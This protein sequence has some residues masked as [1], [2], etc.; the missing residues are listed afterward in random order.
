MIISY[1]ELMPVTNRI[2][3]EIGWN[4][5]Q[6]HLPP[7]VANKIQ[8]GATRNLIIR[9][10]P[11]RYSTNSNSASEKQPITE[12]SIR[13]DLDHIHNLVVISVTFNNGDWYISTNSVHNSL[14]AR[15]CMMSRAKYKGLKIEW[16]PDECSATI[17][18]VQ[19]RPKDNGFEPP[20]KAP[21]GNM[22][23]LL[24]IDDTEDGSSDTDTDAA[25]FNGR[26]GGVGLQWTDGEVMA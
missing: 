13:E 7:H 4:D 8:M 19:P 16:Y 21:L 1:T 14:F 9:S 10:N 11:N 20:K 25:L 5:R 26:P 3:L 23:S 6:F 17:P 15:T 18:R 22:F 12:E 24:E 2:Q